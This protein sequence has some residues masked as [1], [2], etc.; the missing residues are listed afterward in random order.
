MDLA[1]RGPLGLKERVVS[2][3]PKHLARVREL[4]CVICSEYG[5]PQLTSTH[6]HHCIHGRYSQRKT[7]DFMAIPLC[8]GHHQGLYDH[9]KTAIH[10]EPQKWRD[11]YGD[12]T[13]WLSWVEQKLGKD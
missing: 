9:S 5:L 8:E 7:P 4:P 6:A 3:N 12:D 2:R 10:K 1:E 13:G 11:L